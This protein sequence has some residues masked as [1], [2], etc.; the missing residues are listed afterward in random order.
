MKNIDD[1]SIDMILCDLPYGVLNKNNPSAKWDTIIPFEPL[2]EQY[3]RIIKDNGAIILFGQGMFTANLL[4]SNPIM[5]KYNLIWKKSNRISGFL[6]SNR[7]PLRNHE[8]IAVFYNKLPTYNPQMRRG[9]KSHTRG[10]GQNLKNS[11]YGKHDFIQGTEYTTEKFPISVLNFDKDHPP[12]HPTQKPVALCEYLIKTYT[13]KGD[14]VLDNCVGSGTTA[15][16]CKKTS[17]KYIG[18]EDKE[19]YVEIA[20]RRIS[21]IPELLF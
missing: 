14:L 1:K 9:E 18:I 4:I 13:N 8:D 5:W 19:E 10:H 21:A 15:V 11:C 17:R 20:R 7:M 12:V 2:W 3:K 6:N 16:A